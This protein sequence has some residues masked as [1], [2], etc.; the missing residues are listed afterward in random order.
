MLLRNSALLFFFSPEDLFCFFW[1]CPFSAYECFKTVELGAFAHKLT[2][3]EVKKVA[4]LNDVSLKEILGTFLVNGL[5]QS[6]SGK[7]MVWTIP[8]VYVKASSALLEIGGVDD[9]A[10]RSLHDG[11]CSAA[12]FY[13]PVVRHIWTWLGISSTGGQNFKSLLS[14]GYSSFIL[15]LGRVQ[16]AYY[17]E[18]GCETMFL[19][20]R[21]G[22]VQIAMEMGTPWFQDF[23]LA[24]QMCITVGIATVPMVGTEMVMVDEIPFP[25]QVNLDN[26][27]LSLM[28]HGITDV[29]IHF[30]QIK[31][32]AIGVYL[33]PEIVSHLHKWKGKTPVDLA[34]DDDFFEAIINAPVDKLLR[35]VVIKE[36]KGSQYG[37]QLENS[38]KYFK[39][40]SVITFSFPANTGTSKIVFATEGKED[41]AIEV[42]NAN[43]AGMIKKWYLGGTRAVSPSTISSLA[44]TL[45]V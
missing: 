38:S 26:K 33:D 30:L 7:A 36:I 17:M 35:V 37:V 25:P 32:T 23:V 20:S 1:L 21:K 14:F 2:L 19:K 13:T 18:H 42:E 44:N 8:S 27:L 41:S 6:L 28:G 34:Q 3:E 9:E 22:F 5:S 4:S 31:Y 12:V 29:E 15:L 43:V 16:Q 10:E 11:P 39:K 45:P 24:S 40:S